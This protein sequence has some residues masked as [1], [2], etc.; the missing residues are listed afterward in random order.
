MV[1]DQYQCD[2]STISNVFWTENKYECNNDTYGENCLLCVAGS[3]LNDDHTGC[4]CAGNNTEW[5]PLYNT[6]DCI[7]GTFNSSGA[8]IFCTEGS[9]VNLA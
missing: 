8:C 1:G 3:A 6:C 4:V 9:H 2:C 5:S 7:L